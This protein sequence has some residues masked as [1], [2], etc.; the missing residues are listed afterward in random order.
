MP[1][2]YLGMTVPA[3]TDLA[4]GPQ[5]FRDYTDDIDARLDAMDLVIGPGNVRGFATKAALD[6]WTP[7]PGAIGFAVG[8]MWIR[9]DA[10]SGNPVRWCPYQQAG[11]AWWPS[12]SASLQITFPY[13]FTCQLEPVQLVS[14]APDTST[15]TF[16]IINNNPYVNLDLT[17]SPTTTSCVVHWMAMYNH[18]DTVP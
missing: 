14:F 11:T 3:A 12:G 7:S 5:A 8:I 1:N 10:F 13:P 16:N 4:D 18:Q 17:R 6:A 2:E 9:I 15:V